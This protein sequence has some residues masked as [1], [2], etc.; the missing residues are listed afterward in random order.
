LPI[1]PLELGSDVFSRLSE[2]RLDGPGTFSIIVLVHPSEHRSRVVEEIGLIGI[3]GK[4]LL[5]AD[6]DL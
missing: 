3:Q 4:E 2:S 6:A 1:D 5:Q